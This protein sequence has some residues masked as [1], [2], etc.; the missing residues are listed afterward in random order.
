M[1]G[2]DLSLHETYVAS[3]YLKRWYSS[4]VG[5]SRR[6]K[7]SS[8]LGPQ[9]DIEDEVNVI[10]GVVVDDNLVRPGEMSI[11]MLATGELDSSSCAR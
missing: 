11:T 10:F 8:L 3:E 1:G 9:G 5:L 6:Q 4:A 2:S 7:Y